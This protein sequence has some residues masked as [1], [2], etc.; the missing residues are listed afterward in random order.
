MFDSYEDAATVPASVND[1]ILVIDAC[2]QGN[3]SN[4]QTA[5]RDTI[6]LVVSR[7]LM[8]DGVRKVMVKQVDNSLNGAVNSFMLDGM[9][10]TY[11]PT[12]KGYSVENRAVAPTTEVRAYV[13]CLI[14]SVR[15][16]SA[17]YS[18]V[19]LSA[20]GDYFLSKARRE[21]RSTNVVIG[22]IPLGGYDR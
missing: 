7:I 5:V 6:M 10:C 21:V 13:D 20:Q 8:E 14:P 2:R 22:R 17:K 12:T 18:L 15:S 3:V 11:I 1:L 19:S 4:G 9:N 16:G